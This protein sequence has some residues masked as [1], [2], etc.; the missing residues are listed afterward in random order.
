M[1]TI[2]ELRKKIDAIDDAIIK[3]IAQ[4]NALVI[5]I[6]KIKHQTNSKV[7]DT[8]R[9]EQ[10]IARYEKLSLTYSLKA[11][12]IKR[13]FKMII[14]NSRQLQESRKRSRAE[15]PPLKKEA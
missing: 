7:L 15:S 13:L 10:L 3:K 9:E 1:T 2:K 8:K 12:F 11:D 4:R 5:K 6:G 14:A